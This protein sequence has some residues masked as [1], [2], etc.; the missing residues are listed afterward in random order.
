MSTHTQTTAQV[1]AM[2]AN[3]PQVEKEV[4]KE[5]RR[6]TVV[7]HLLALRVKKGMT[8]EDIAAAMRCTPSKISRL[9]ASSDVNLKWTDIV[10][11]TRALKLNIQL[12]I[13]DPEMPAAQNIK[14]CVFRIRRDLDKLTELAKS[15]NGDDVAKK[16]HQFSGEVLLNFLMQY[17]DHASELS[18]VINVPSRVQ[19]AG[20]DGLNQAEPPCP[21]DPEPVP[22]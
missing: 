9:E 10:G 12:S 19:P 5:I 20:F 3:D 14:R 21:A 4:E 17:A 7:S 15:S 13:D 6:N 18:S 8:Q 22:A 16:I 2:L 1:A 11:Y